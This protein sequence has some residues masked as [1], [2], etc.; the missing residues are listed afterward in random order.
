MTPEQ[1]RINR[2]LRE[3]RAEIRAAKLPPGDYSAY[4]NFVSDNATLECVMTCESHWDA[5]LVLLAI[6][7]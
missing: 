2:E 6:N 5:C 7:K 3:S 4:N 1:V